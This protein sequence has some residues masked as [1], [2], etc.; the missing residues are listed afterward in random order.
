MKFE[1]IQNDYELA[2]EPYFKINELEVFEIK[3]E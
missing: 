1:G 3:F 2:D